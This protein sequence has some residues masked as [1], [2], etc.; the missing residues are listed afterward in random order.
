MRKQEGI[1]D[2]TKLLRISPF[3]EW[4]TIYY[5]PKLISPEKILTLIKSNRCP[6][7][8]FVI[9]KQNR[10][11]LPAPYVAPGDIVQIEIK[12][13][14]KDQIDSIELPKGWK[15]L[16]SK[17]LIKGNNIIN[18]QTPT[19]TTQKRTKINIKTEKGI[20]I[21]AGIEVVQKV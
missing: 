7:A 21:H 16:S 9:K 10:Y 5:N 2:T 1:Y 6:N 3:A 19:S 13:A 12:T 20:T 11:A 8:K 18:I 15:L 17:E 14:S 4:V